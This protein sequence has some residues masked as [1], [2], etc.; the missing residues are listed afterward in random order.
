MNNIISIHI[1]YLARIGCNY[2][3]PKHGGETKSN[4]MAVLISHAIPNNSLEDKRVI[5]KSW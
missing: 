2:I 4:A 5:A 1:A 3:V